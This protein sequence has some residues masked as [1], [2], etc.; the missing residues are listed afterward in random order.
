[1]KKGIIYK[2]ME[3]F[4]KKC[5]KH[6]EFFVGEIGATPLCYEC[7]KEFNFNW[8]KYYYSPKI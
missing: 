3:K 6:N 4:D 1:M 8:Q 7:F 2:I 5:I